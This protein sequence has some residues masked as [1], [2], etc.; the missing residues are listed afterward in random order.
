MAGTAEVAQPVLEQACSL[1]GQRC[2]CLG[3]GEGADRLVQ[4]RAKGHRDAPLVEARFGLVAGITDGC[5]GVHL[6]QE[7]GAAVGTDEL[8][9]RQLEREEG[10]VEER[11][12]GDGLGNQ[13]VGAGDGRIGLVV[14]RRDGGGGV[15]VQHRPHRSGASVGIG[16][17]WRHP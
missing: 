3:G 17:A 15:V 16:H 13:V 12:R 7:R 14:D 8:G 2:R 1:P 5:I 4:V 10:G 11:R 9:G 6:A